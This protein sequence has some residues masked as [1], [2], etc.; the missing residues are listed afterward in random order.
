MSRAKKLAVVAVMTLVLAVGALMLFGGLDG[1]SAQAEP[2][3]KVLIEHYTGSE[4]NPVVVICVDGNAVPAH[5]QE[6]GDYNIGP[7]FTD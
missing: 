7:C 5:V 3:P 4:T 1:G 2:L 6:H